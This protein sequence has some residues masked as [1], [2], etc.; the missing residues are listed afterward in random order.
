MENE[1]WF[2]LYDRETP[3]EIKAS[4]FNSLLDVVNQTFEK[5]SGKKVLSSFGQGVT[6]E[7]IDDMSKKLA[8]FLIDQVGLQKYDRVA[9]MLPN[10]FQYPI[11]LLGILRAGLTAVNI[12]LLYNAKELKTIFIDSEAKAIIT[13]DTFSNVIDKCYEGTSLERVFFTG[14]GDFLSFPKSFITNLSQFNIHQT[15]S[16]ENIEG[17]LSLKDAVYRGDLNSYKDPEINESDIAFLQ[18]TGGTTGPAKAVAITHKNILSAMDQMESW[19]PGKFKERFEVNF[20]ALPLHHIFSIVNFFLFLKWGA[21]NILVTFPRSIDEIVKT[22]KD[23]KP[24]IFFGINPL[25][26]AIS[27]H[28]DAK[29]IDFSNLKISLAGAVPLQKEVFEKWKEMTGSSILEVYTITEACG[30]AAIKPSSPEGYE[31]F[32]GIPPSST[33]IRVKG[34]GG[35]EMAVGEIGEIAIKG[36]QVIE[37]YWNRPE[38]NNELKA[39][40][41]FLLTGD[42][43]FMDEKGRL[44]IVDRKKDVIVVSGLYVYPDEIDEVLKKNPKV[45]DAA[46]IGV[47]DSAKG[48][49]VKIFVV[50]KDFSLTEDELR[51]YCDTH[52]RGGKSPEHI[53]FIK[54][55]PRTN[56]GKILRKKLRDL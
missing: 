24:T 27:E 48:Q 16:L 34:D 21:S 38:E 32:T 45:L 12:S 23:V 36:P 55:I 41:G 30:F 10:I 42:F 56:I 47:N 4:E 50:K 17:S 7:K 11:C 49:V 3:K 29:K 13:L 37:S 9:I 28:R 5:F 43:G 54:A 18:Y 53:E 26:K 33:L 8:S 25:F 52:L 22:L 20:L 35:A 31:E 15:S 14:L 51:L 39:K 2:D 46:A 1:K 19:F 40:D 6:I 44:K